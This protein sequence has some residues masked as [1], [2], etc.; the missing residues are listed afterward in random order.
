MHSTLS[1]S[2]AVVGVNSCRWTKLSFRSRA[3]AFCA[4]DARSLHY[5]A[6]WLT[7]YTFPIPQ[8]SWTLPVTVD[9]P[10]IFAPHYSWSG[11]SGIFSDPRSFS[12]AAARRGR[13]A[14]RLL[15][16]LGSVFSL[17]THQRLLISFANCLRTAISFNPPKPKL[18]LVA[19]FGVGFRTRCC[20]VGINGASAAARCGGLVRYRGAL[21]PPARYARSCQPPRGGGEASEQFRCGSGI[22]Q[23]RCR[24]SSRFVF[25][26]AIAKETMLALELL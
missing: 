14:S 3:Q 24:S 16:I 12:R 18:L 13:R 10:R 5:S 21:P 9:L 8:G 15:L 7:T 1:G 2:C 6:G 4:K 22:R 19:S 11:P 25:Y 23:S 20:L 17:L 26:W